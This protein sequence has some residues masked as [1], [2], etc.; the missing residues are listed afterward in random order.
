MVPANPSPSN[1]RPWS[2]TRRDGQTKSSPQHYR[3]RRRRHG[4]KEQK[5]CPGLRLTEGVIKS[6]PC[7]RFLNVCVDATCGRG[8]ASFTSSQLL[9]IHPRTPFH[10]FMRS[11]SLHPPPHSPLSTSTSHPSLTSDF[12]SGRRHT[13]CIAT[14]LAAVEVASIDQRPVVESTSPVQITR[15][16]QVKTR[17][18]SHPPP[19]QS[20]TT[21]SI[22]SLA[23]ST[24][25]GKP[26]PFYSHVLKM[27]T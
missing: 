14:F 6:R 4:R 8:V 19:P 21:T 13:P 9:I 24:H 22:N 25:R 15:E 12:F 7:R 2:R 17:R 27:R 20:T 18:Y 16:G 1:R 11:F 3:R 23:P 10:V 26:A 5:I